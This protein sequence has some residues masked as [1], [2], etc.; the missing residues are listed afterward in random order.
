VCAGL[1]LCVSLQAFAVP[2]GEILSESALRDECS[3]NFGPQV[4]IRECVKKAATKSEKALK[5][6]EKDAI[7][8]LSKWDTDDEYI[9]L[10]KSR[11]TASGE[12]FAKFRADQCSFAASL[13]G[14]AIVAALDMRRDA[15]I[16]EL[17]NRRA[18]QLHDF[19]DDLG[20]K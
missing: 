19:V 3:E 2:E 18:K 15:C 20:L 10:A 7:N 14:G 12:T 17:N 6:A 13:G 11:L 16:A 9:N 1:F 5:Q 8:T 4:T